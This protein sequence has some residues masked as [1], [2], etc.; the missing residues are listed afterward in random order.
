MVKRKKKNLV[1]RLGARYGKRIRDRV[2][3]V[4]VDLRRKHP[5]VR[6]GFRAVK[7]VSVGVWKCRKCGVTFTGAAYAPSSDL[8]VAAQRSIRGS[9]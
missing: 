3:E 5:C 2:A 9:S 8:G 7:R 4:E 1:G 6:C